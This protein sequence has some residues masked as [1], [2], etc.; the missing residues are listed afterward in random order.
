MAVSREERNTSGVT[1]KRMGD[2]DTAPLGQSSRLSRVRVIT[3]SSMPSLEIAT[4]ER[5]YFIKSLK[6][7]FPGIFS[8]VVALL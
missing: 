7:F 4:G 6:I 5:K 2:G 3:L 1:A 8:V